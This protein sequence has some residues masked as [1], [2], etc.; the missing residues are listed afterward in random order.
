MIHFAVL[1]GA[2]LLDMLAGDDHFVWRRFKHPIVHIGNLIGWADKLL[3]REETA[4]ITRE[5]LGDL[6]IVVLIIFAVLVG[7]VLEWAFAFAGWFSLV[8]EAFLVSVFLAHR[9][10]IDHVKAVADGLKDGGLEEGRA[11]VAMIVGRDVKQLDEAGVSRAAIESLAENFSD[12]VIAPAFWYLV[13]GLPGILAYKVINTAD[14]MVGHMDERYRAFGRA[15]AKIDDLANWLPAR[16]TG[17]LLCLYSDPK[18]FAT[19]WKRFKRAWRVMRKDAHLHRSPNAGWPE[20]AM[21]GQLDI[22]LGG[23]RFYAGGVV[24]D[25]PFLNAGGREE[26]GERD[27]RNAIKVVE[28][29][30]GLVLLTLVIIALTSLT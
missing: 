24:A 12:G 15:S 23:P 17:I 19:D 2:L 29:A 5:K 13:F 21:A 26:I 11:K 7:L 10:L 6:T 9:S 16:M 4:E 20:A 30:I 3:N 27:V 18:V 22:A 28:E 1:F 14:S 8:L 25:E